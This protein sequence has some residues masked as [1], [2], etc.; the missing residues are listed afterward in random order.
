[1]NNAKR[2]R[3][4]DEYGRKVGRMARMSHCEGVQDVPRSIGAEFAGGF[5]CCGCSA[6]GTWE[7]LKAVVVAP[8]DSSMTIKHLRQQ[9]R[10]NCYNCEDC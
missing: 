5:L 4:E 10:R 3:V 1:M 7:D 2:I 8:H 9:A 6:F